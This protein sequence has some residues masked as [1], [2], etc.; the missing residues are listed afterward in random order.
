VRITADVLL[1]SPERPESEITATSALGLQGTVA[2]QAPVTTLSGTLAPLSQTFVSAAALLPARCAARLSGGRA[3][4]LVLSGRE[5]LPLEPSG[6]LPSP[7]ALEERLIADPAVAREPSQKLP[8]PR[9]TLLDHTA[10]VLPR[11]RPGDLPL[12]AR[13][14]WNRGCPR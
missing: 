4:S 8:A 9:G 5:G 2:I 6:L 12:V 10:K 11:M 7:L 1:T 3:S 14:V 13:A